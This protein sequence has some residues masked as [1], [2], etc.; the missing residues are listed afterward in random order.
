MKRHKHVYAIDFYAYHSPMRA[1]NAMLKVWSAILF[2]FLCIILDN[3][4]ASVFLMFSMSYMVIQKGKVHIQEYLSLLTIP[5]SFILIGSIAIA[6]EIGAKPIGVY[7]LSIGQFY[8]CVTG[9]S[10]MKMLHVMLNAVAA[11]SVLYMMT[12]STPMG[13]VIIV[14]KRAHVP[15]LITEL[16]YMIYR[17]IF[18]LL[19][20]QSRMR[21]AAESRLGYCDFQ[22]SCRTFGYSMGSL[23]VLSIQKSRNYFNAMESRCYDGILSF[24][25]EE[26][27]IEKIQ[28][29]GM[30]VIALLMIVIAYYT[31]G[32][33]WKQF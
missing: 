4:C 8:F 5:L 22:T 7:Q 21:K 10:V 1:W 20:V 29:L 2:I 18:I 33:L 17:F 23:L 6:V 11:V 28:I 24:M 26:K 14:L 25:E 30:S 15:Q 3:I 13:E 9:K 27:K 12:L 32:Q 31:E 16:M 19:D